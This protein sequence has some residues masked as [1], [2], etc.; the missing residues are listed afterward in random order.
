MEKLCSGEFAMDEGQSHSSDI[1]AQARTPEDAIRMAESRYDLFDKYAAG[2]DE[3][4]FLAEPVVAALHD[5]GLVQAF[6]PRDLG[7]L[8]LRPTAPMRLIATVSSGDPS[9]GWVGMALATAGG[10]AGAF[11]PKDTVTDLF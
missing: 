10:W 6:L 11:L 9:A 8:E 7:G 3:R 4:G 2:N 1:G 5:T